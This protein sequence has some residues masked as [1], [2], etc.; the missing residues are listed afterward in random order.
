MAKVLVVL[1]KVE[2]V[3]DRVIAAA[4]R[5]EARVGSDKPPEW[6]PRMIMCPAVTSIIAGCP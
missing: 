4:V 5:G 2:E 3:K 6:P 1:I